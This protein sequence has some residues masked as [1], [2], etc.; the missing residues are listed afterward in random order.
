MQIAKQVVGGDERLVEGKTEEYKKYWYTNYRLESLVEL[1]ELIESSMT[2]TLFKKVKQPVLMLYFYKNE[3][4]QDPVVKVDAML[5][6]FSE[7][8]TPANLKQKVAIPN[9]G[10]HV[11]GSYITS[12][13]LPAVEKAIDD[14]VVEKLNVKMN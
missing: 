6:M 10:A 7:L 12:N 2:P 4:E 1:E 11:L 8:G 3:Q 9:G 14:F 5:K 13:D